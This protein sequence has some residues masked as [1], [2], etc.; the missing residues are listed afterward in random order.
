MSMMELQVI[1]HGDFLWSIKSM[2]TTLF[3]RL[4][5]CK[6]SPVLLLKL[7]KIEKN[8]LLKKKN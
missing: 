8:D 6:N 5:L 4:S 7:F 1:M 2:K 3:L